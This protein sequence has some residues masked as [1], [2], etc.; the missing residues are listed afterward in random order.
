MA[1]FS[2]D[3]WL[4]LG[5]A[6]LS[7]HG[8][9]GLRIDPLCAAAGRTRGSFYHHFDDH[10]AFIAA[11]LDQWREW[12]TDGVIE[13]VELEAEIS[14]KRGRLN[15]LA[16]GLDQQ[17]EVAIRRFAA[18]NA[19]AA[20]AVAEVD[21]IRIAYLA[22]MNEEEFAANHARARILAEIEY[23]A[24]IGFQHLYPEAAASRLI[25]IGAALEEMIAGA[26]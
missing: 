3:D 26:A 1:R 13:M 15:A 23:A 2:R 25:E 20:Q 7:A 19:P 18:A 17:M 10:D 14:G 4:V 21:E 6:Q 22:R 16:S 24:F 12:N 11:L 9:D 8:P 5:L